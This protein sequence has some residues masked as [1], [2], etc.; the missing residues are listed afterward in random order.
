MIILVE[1]LLNLSEYRDS[2]IKKIIWKT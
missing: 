1:R 2:Q